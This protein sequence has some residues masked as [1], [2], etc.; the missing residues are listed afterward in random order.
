MF[1]RIIVGVDATEGGRDAIALARRLIDPA[2]RMS[3][4]NVYIESRPPARGSSGNWRDAARGES[5]ELLRRAREDEEIEA[6]LVPVE[7][8][9]V[10]Q[11]L[12]ELADRTGADL[13]VVGSSHRGAIG[14]VLLGDDMRSALSGA[15]CAVGVAPRAYAGQQATIG[16]VG[17]G[18]DETP[19]SRE[20]LR[21]ARQVAALQGGRVSAF[22]ALPLTTEIVMDL[23]HLDAE[24]PDELALVRDRLRALGDVEPHVVYGDPGSELVLFSASIDLL[25][26]G[27]RGDGPLGRMTHGRMALRLA[28]E[29]HC[30]VLVTARAIPVAE[31]RE[32]YTDAQTVGGSRLAGEV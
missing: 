13:L 26:V 24:I 3:L 7:A 25:V 22:E 14:R 10:G 21:V 16:E 31:P 9:S 20:A 28:R 2:G 12:H 15:P 8:S 4:A 1:D 32:E 19:E 11:G 6:E 23:K 5:L 29:A 27:S 30:P 18:Y 17:V